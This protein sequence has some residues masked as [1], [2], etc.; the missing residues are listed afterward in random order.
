MTRYTAALALLA[1][2]GAAQAQDRPAKPR[3]RSARYAP[4][5]SAVV[6]AEIARSRLMQAKGEWT[7]MLA[8]AAPYADM[9]APLRVKAADWLKG[10]TNPPIAARRRPYAVWM[11]CDG[12]NALALGGRGGTGAY[13]TAWQRQPKKGEFKWTL[14]DTSPTGDPE[15]AMIAGRVAA[16]SGKPGPVPASPPPQ[17]V[18]ARDGRSHDNTLQWSSWVYP[19]GRRLISAWLWNGAGFDAVVNFNV[20]SAPERG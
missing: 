13:V 15:P 4:N 2:T 17:G 18:A 20:G 3:E 8:T 5:P 7:A 11:S 12:T 10:R 6:A 16:C 19:D 1:L 9:F 14:D